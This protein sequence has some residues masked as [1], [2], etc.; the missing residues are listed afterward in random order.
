M[1]QFFKCSQKEANVGELKD[2]LVSTFLTE[3]VTNKLYESQSVWEGVIYCINKYSTHKNIDKVLIPIIQDAAM[4]RIHELLKGSPSIKPIVENLA[5]N[6]SSP[7]K[8]LIIELINTGV[9]V[10]D[11][12]ESNVVPK[13][14]K[15]K[16]SSE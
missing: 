6:L 5:N 4:S 9:V 2:W 1:S 15:S 11:P 16:K 13:K 8:E 12:E 10:G 3:I 14:K 7:R